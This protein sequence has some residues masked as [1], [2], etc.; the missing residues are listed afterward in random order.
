M[1]RDDESADHSPAAAPHEVAADAS[2]HLVLKVA[3]SRGPA[4]EHR[5]DLG[6]I[7][8]G[9]SGESDLQIAD[10]SLSRRHALLT[11][12]DD[13]VTIEDLGSRNGTFVNEMPVDGPVA[14][15]AGDRV[16][17]GASEIEITRTSPVHLTDGDSTAVDDATA[18]FDVTR[19]DT[20]GHQANV[21]DDVAE[22]NRALALVSRAGTLLI[23]HE[24]LP[25]ILGEV[26]DLAI[27]HFEADRAAVAL[28]APGASEPEVAQARGPDG[29]VDLRLSRTVAQTVLT[30]RKAVAVTDVEADPRL[31]SADSVRLQG[32][33][34]LMCTPL[35]DGSSV[36]GLLYVDRRIGRGD[37]AEADL[38]VLSMLANV[39]AVKIE[40]ARLLE[41]QITRRRLEE[42]LAVAAR[43]QRRLMP[44]EAPELGGLAIHGICRACT[45]V[46]GDFF[47]Y[48]SLPG[49]GL[50]VMVAD[51][52][53]K[54]VGSALLGA[55]LQ[56]ALRGALE[57]EVEADER[58]AWLNGYLHRHSPADR[59]VTAAWLEISPDGRTVRHAVAG[60]PPPLLIG[61]DGQVAS[62]EEGGLPLGLFADA[63]F[64]AGSRTL[65]SGERLVLYTDGVTEAAPEGRREPAFGTHRLVEAVASGDPDPVAACSRVFEALD[66]F[67]DG[68]PLRDDATVVVIGHD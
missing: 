67:T 55:S 49:G 8:I 48:L 15:R 34:S 45:E 37:Y 44:A 30:Q 2:A 17:V 27:E 66:A 43:I 38:K 29:P 56:A 36:R 64:E 40:N 39:L 52:C 50:G 23:R 24:P 62:L 33:N 6:A 28:L 4:F 18:I 9:R 10:E 21:F 12:R 46:G 65:R 53:G 22:E 47:D 25:R 11:V 58:L 1:Q 32:V 54:G 35:W 7:T 14:V 13:G 63:T 60:H 51:V 20:R 3:P 41:D 31:S 59:Y 5:A 57:A 61:T 26:L 19:L 68:A 42:E 16:Q